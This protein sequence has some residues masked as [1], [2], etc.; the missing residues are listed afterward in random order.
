MRRLLDKYYRPGLECDG[1]TRVFHTIL[2]NY[3]V[4]HTVYIGSISDGRTTVSPHFWIVW[5]GKIV[6]YQA[7]RWLGKSA[8]HGIFKPTKII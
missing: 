8:H 5:N 3:G 4:P 6:D 1:Q 7:R 2:T